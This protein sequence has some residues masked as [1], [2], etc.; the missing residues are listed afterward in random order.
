MN[1]STTTLQTLKEQAQQIVEERDWGQFHTPKN[2]SMN[3]AIEAAELMELFVWTEGNAPQTPENR[4][5]IE[6]ELADVIITALM[7]ASHLDIDITQAVHSKMAEIRKKYPIEKAK[8]RNV[9]Y[10]EL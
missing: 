6:Q 1:D 7:F 4:Q 2:L 3:L 8:G 5:R 9:K 10:T